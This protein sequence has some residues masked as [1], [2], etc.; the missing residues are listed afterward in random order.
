[1]MHRAARWSRALT[2]L[3]TPWRLVGLAAIVAASSA[4]IGSP[5]VY[6]EGA[7]GPY[8]VLV[9]V[10]MPGV[11]PGDSQIAVRVSGAN[12]TTPSRVA[13]GVNHF[14]TVTAP[15]LEDAARDA[16]DPRSY[17]GKLWVMASG[18]N[19]VTVQ[20][21]G[22][23][24][25]GTAVVPV[26][27]VA[28]QRLTLY[29]WLGGVLAVIGLALFLGAV[30]IAGAAVRE[31]TLPPGAVPDAPRRR[32]ARY[33]MAAT[34]VFVA[35]ILY[36]GRNWWNSED[37]SFQ[38]ELYH[39]MATRAEVT[40]GGR[41]LAFTITDSEWTHR[42]DTTWQIAHRATDWGPLIPDH[43]KIMH[44]FLISD[45]APFAFAHLHPTTVDSNT[46]TVQ[47]PPLAAG[48][49]RVFADMVHESG[50][51]KTLVATIDLP[52]PSIPAPAPGATPS[53]ARAATHAPGARAATD[54]ARDSDDTWTAAA[55]IPFGSQVTLADGSTLR[56]VGSSA[57]PIAGGDAGLRFV[58]GAPDGHP[59][60]LQPYMGMSGHA[61]VERD[62]GSVFIH[63][64]PMGTISAASQ[65]AFAVRTAADTIDGEVATRIAASTAAMTMPMPASDTVSFPYSFPQPGQYHVWVQV[66]RNGVVLTAPLLVNVQPP[67]TVVAAR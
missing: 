17:L 49:Y 32:R 13:V 8:H 45:S 31:S 38:R 50:F 59:A 22:P 14:S 28:T 21:T 65:M 18:S 16:A 33:A 37:Q 56:L 39:P 29:P 2:V 64:H 57:A 30:S 9:V 66:K 63:L 48:R 27:A 1:M 61:V 4:H 35:L 67:A 24:G 47:I 25:T 36:G 60:T 26:V 44:L 3:W 53:G 55:A 43:G 5:D 51:D 20:V 46:F 41:A 40:D 42:G 23:A 12:G 62:D 19:E 58:V 6:Y 34:A 15:P 10:R 11:V 54:A 7:A 52:A